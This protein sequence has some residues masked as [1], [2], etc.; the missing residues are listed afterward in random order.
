MNE[1]LKSAFETAATGWKNMETICDVFIGK[2]VES[3]WWQRRKQQCR[4][5]YNFCMLRATE[6]LTNNARAI[7]TVELAERFAGITTENLV[8]QQ[9]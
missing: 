6:S 7:S 8:T 5:S 4:D 1:E 3:C 2:G 9:N